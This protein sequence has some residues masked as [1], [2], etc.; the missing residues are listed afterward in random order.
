MPKE[1]VYSFV[2]VG[3]LVQ[4]LGPCSRAWIYTIDQDQGSNPSS[5]PAFGSPFWP[6]FLSCLVLRFKVPVLDVILVS[7]LIHIYFWSA[8]VPV[9]VTLSQPPSPWAGFSVL[10]CHYSFVLYSQSTEL[11]W[12]GTNHSHVCSKG[13]ARARDIDYTAQNRKKKKKKEA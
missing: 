3:G 2:H 13:P 8:L 10:R 4:V 12:T 5:H 11:R 7:D 6:R 1:Q 9:L